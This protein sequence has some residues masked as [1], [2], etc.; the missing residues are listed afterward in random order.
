MD[1]KPSWL[2]L[3]VISSLIAILFQVADMVG[4]SLPIPQEALQSSLNDI[5]TMIAAGVAIYGRF[6]AKTT[7]TVL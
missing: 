3:T 4:F 6:R 7:L 1:V 2:S 5:G